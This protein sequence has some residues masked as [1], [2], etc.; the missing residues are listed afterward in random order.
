MAIIAL[1]GFTIPESK[2]KQTGECA[3]MRS[4]VKRSEVD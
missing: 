3:P 1:Q 4:E 2:P